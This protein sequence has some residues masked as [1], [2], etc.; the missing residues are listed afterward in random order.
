METAIVAGVGPGLGA[1]LARA[2]SKEDCAVGLLSRRVQSGE[3]VAAEIRSHGGKALALSVDVTQRDAV[4]EAIDKIR[5]ELGP[6]TTG[7]L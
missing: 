4:F 6:I 7:H 3:P 5:A 1:S 2:F